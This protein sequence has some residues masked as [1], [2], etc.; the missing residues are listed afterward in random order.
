MKRVVV[1][2]V[3]ILWLF[4]WSPLNGKGE[5]LD[6]FTTKSHP[7]SFQ[8]N[9]QVSYYDLLIPPNQEEVL[10]VSVVN[11]LDEPLTIATSFNRAITN[12][13]G[14][15]EYS[16]HKKDTS[17][18]MPYDIET[19][20]K[21]EEELIQ[22]QP[23]E[24]KDIHVTIKMPDKGFQGVLAGAIYLIEV[25]QEEQEGN[26]RNI[27]SREIAVLLRHSD[28]KVTP[29]IA[30]KGMREER[31]NQRQLLTILMENTTPTYIHDGQV[32]YDIQY[33]GE[34]FMEGKSNEVHIAP[35]TV[36][37]Y[38]IELDDL[39]LEPG[40]YEGTVSFISSNETWEETLSLRIPKEKETM[41]SK[42]EVA[43]TSVTPKDSKERWDRRLFIIVF[44]ISLGI[45]VYSLARN[46]QLKKQLAQKNNLSDHHK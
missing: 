28:Q 19:I 33:K 18:T 1:V 46:R 31:S 21:V 25:P 35:N 4:N 39:T 11:Q 15:V 22:L 26:I 13:L 27:L 42:K 7:S 29:Q 12:S 10:I 16:G 45:A 17:T 41:L 38:Q 24:R 36:F 14:V 5:T 6:R 44:A 20:V 23:K 34:P 9:E 8:K 32:V 2:I 43:T 37:P 30:F 3:G 40:D